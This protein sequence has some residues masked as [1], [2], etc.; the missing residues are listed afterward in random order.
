MYRLSDR[1]SE[2]SEGA[3]RKC[4]RYEENIQLQ[5]KTNIVDRSDP[6]SFLNFP[7]THGQA[8]DY[9][10]GTSMWSVKH[11]LTGPAAASLASH[12]YLKK[13]KTLYKPEGMLSSWKRKS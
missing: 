7:A 13:K 9:N 10:G 2:Y 11:F 4:A 3:A 5:M 1:A 12:L 6:I 8:Y